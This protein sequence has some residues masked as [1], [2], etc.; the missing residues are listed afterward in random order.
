MKRRC[1]AATALD[2]QRSTPIKKAKRVTR[3]F[4]P[5]QHFKHRI[6]RIRPGGERGAIEFASRHLSA[7]DSL[8]QAHHG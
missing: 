2:V 4:L 7:A 6:A 8:I 5:L 3:L 1:G